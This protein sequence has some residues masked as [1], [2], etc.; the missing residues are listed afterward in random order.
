MRRLLTSLVAA[1]ALLLV[2]PLPARAQTAPPPPT[3]IVPGPGL[4]GP[5]A[6]RLP[7]PPPEKLID[8]P[9]KS[10][11]PRAKTVQVGGALGLLSTTLAVTE[12]T[13]IAVE[14]APASLQ[15]LREGDEVNASY[16]TREGKNVATSIGVTHPE[17]TGGAGPM[18][19][20]PGSSTAPQ[21]MELR[22]P[23]APPPGGAKTP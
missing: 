4:V 18:K 21:W 8:G 9:V 17:A 7:S 19:R 22:E 12:D 11:D 1:A 15:D 10:V 6:A 16:E 14:G 5:P 13:Q 23:P 2:I 20:G 3:Y